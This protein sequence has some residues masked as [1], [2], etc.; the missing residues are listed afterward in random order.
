VEERKGLYLNISGAARRLKLIHCRSTFGL[1]NTIVW[2]VAQL[3]EQALISFEE[4]AAEGGKV[5]INI[6]DEGVMRVIITNAVEKTTLKGVVRYDKSNAPILASV[7]DVERELEILRK[8]LVWY[9][10]N[11]FGSTLNIAGFEAEMAQ[12]EEDLSFVAD[13]AVAM[14]ALTLRVAGLTDELEE[15]SLDNLEASIAKLMGPTVATPRIEA[16]WQASKDAYTAKKALAKERRDA[17][18]MSEA[19]KRLAQNKARCTNS[20]E[21]PARREAPSRPSFQVHL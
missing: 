19:Q 6:S 1:F 8:N 21:R 20:P 3:R 14:R 5:G 11:G 9:A 16:I 10:A 17:Q 7:K 4:F 15:N 18:A 2:V 13:N 12:A